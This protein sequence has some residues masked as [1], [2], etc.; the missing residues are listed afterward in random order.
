[1]VATRDITL[2]PQNAALSKGLA[3][4]GPITKSQA[5]RCSR[6]G[7]QS[8][9]P[10]WS[11]VLHCAVTTR[12]QDVYKSQWYSETRSTFVYLCTNLTGMYDFKNNP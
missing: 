5:T 9:L 11:V 2:G 4:G 12:L 8:P 6:V 3:T 7:L 10:H 1:M